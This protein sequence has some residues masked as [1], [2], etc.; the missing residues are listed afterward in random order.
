MYV[1]PIYSCSY[2]CWNNWGKKKK[3]NTF[4]LL[5]QS[6]ER[7]TFL[8][9][10]ECSYPS[11]SRTTSNA[12]SYISV[13]YEQPPSY[14]N[15]FSVAYPCVPHQVISY[16]SH[17]CESH[18]HAKEN[19]V[20]PSALGLSDAAHEMNHLAFIHMQPGSVRIRVLTNQRHEQVSFP[21]AHGENGEQFKRVFTSPWGSSISC[22]ILS[23]FPS[24]VSLFLSPAS[25]PGSFPK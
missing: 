13:D 15:Q 10:M 14:N 21:F 22:N 2:V 11:L 18:F 20:L 24:F 3:K 17:W 23:C 6:Q 5:L 8:L 16:S 1:C 9:S 4:N 19:C 7:P 25:V 12:I